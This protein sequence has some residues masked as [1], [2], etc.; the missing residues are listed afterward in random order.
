M[1]A[2]KVIESKNTPRL[3]GR[4]LVKTGS[5]LMMLA[6]PDKPQRFEDNYTLNSCVTEECNL[7]DVTWLHPHLY[8]PIKKE[9]LNISK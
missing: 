9:I 1:I 8:R 5:Q 3:V 4:Y 2:Y 6:T 7:E